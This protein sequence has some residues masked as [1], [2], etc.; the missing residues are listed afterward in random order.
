MQLFIFSAKKITDCQLHLEKSIST[1]VGYFL[2]H[3]LKPNS[4]KTEF[5]VF[6]TSSAAES[7]KV[8]NHI[9]KVE[10]V[11]YIGVILDR[12]F[13]NNKLNKNSARWRTLSSDT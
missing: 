7:I 13:N 8:D 11:K 3:V 5:I 4:E 2:Y 1:L 10:K 9:I 6:G 12:K